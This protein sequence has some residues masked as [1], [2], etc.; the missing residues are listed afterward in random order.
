MVIDRRL[1]FATPALALLLAACSGPQ[2]PDL[3]VHGGP[4]LTVDAADAVV[5]AI[6]C[7]D[8]TIT[9]SGTASA[10]LATR[11]PSTTVIDLEGR[12]LVPG[13][14][15]AHEHPTLTAVFGGA[16]DVS[17][18][19][20]ASD[21]DVWSA[22]R[23]AVA[24]TP[25]G[26]WIHAMGLDP[27]LV[28]DLVLPTRRGLDEIAPDHPLVVISQTMHSFWANSR[29]F[30]AAGITRDIPDPG[31]G[32]FYG[33]DESGELTGFV[34]ESAA[35]APMLEPLKSPWR[36]ISRY[37]AALDELVA[38]GF[39]SV[40]SL[41]FNVPPLLAR[42]ASSK[43]GRP[44]IRQVVYTADVDRSYLPERPDR[45]DPFFRIQGVKLWHDGSPYTGSMFLD[46]PYLDTP[47]SRALG[48]APGSR[49][50]A[51]IAPDELVALLRRHS[52]QGWQVAIHS[53]GD[54]SN[55]E[56]L[57]ALEQVPD[58]PDVAPRRLEHGVLLP[59]DAL[60]RMAALRVTP[61]F[62]VNHL[63]YY[64]D[65][66]VESILGPER[67]ARIL[68]I[69]S[70]FE[71]GLRPTLHADSP[72]FPPEPLSLMRTAM[73]RRTRGGRVLGEDE[74]IDARQALR[75]M[76]IHGAAQLGLEDLVGSLE[77]GKQADFTVLSGNPYETPAEGIDRLRV[78]D[79][80]LAGRRVGP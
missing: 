71:L 60:A 65:A 49:G 16:V 4:I 41:G 12:A 24:A 57:D 30:E 47:L 23:A 3:I 33:R 37:E 78:E 58:R 38:A 48:I 61:S 64:G 20:H 69:R 46:E 76:T 44:R 70:A 36:M 8:G 53:Q 35:A 68:P 73:L 5:E 32:S 66:L 9:S 6:A 17:G 54:A 80:Y 1:R 19:T 14:V 62:H 22:L 56:V 79:V 45:G 18:F 11:S 42:W 28:P 26:R 43:G 75:A 15:A 34:S 40:G 59:K 2:G 29:A 51:M 7:R 21:E 67:A 72:M 50:E 63:W 27:V 31:R 13:F 10:I 52:E 25:K 39:T 77:P 74:A 55:R